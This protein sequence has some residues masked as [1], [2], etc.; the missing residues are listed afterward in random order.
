ML[1]MSAVRLQ[2]G[3]L[4]AAD[5]TT[6]APASSANKIAL[7]AEAFTPSEDLVIGDLTLATFTGS[8]PKAGATGAQQAGIDPATHD[9]VITILAPAGGYRFECTVTPTPAETI[10]G[11]ALTDNAG[12]VLLGVQAFATPIVIAEVGDFIDL[13]AVEMTLVNQPIS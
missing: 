13:G 5:D 4:L 8:A 2:L 10:Y 7:I 6:L 11:Y 1:P 3:E 9:Q 12:A